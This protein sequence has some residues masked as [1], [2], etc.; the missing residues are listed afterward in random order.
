MRR[1]VF[2]RFL[3]LISCLAFAGT[4][5][6]V[7]VQGKATVVDGDTLKV[8]GHTI[9]ILNIDAPEADQFCENVACGSEATAYLR[10]LTRR[11]RVIC[12]AEARD[13]YGRLLAHCT[14]R[15]KDLGALMVQSGHAAAYRKY[16]SEYVTEERR[17]RARKLGIWASASP[18][19]P[20]EHRAAARTPRTDTPRLITGQ[21]C[22][23]KGN[24]SQRDGTRIYHL[25]GQEYY[26][27][28]RIDPRAGERWFCSEQE[29][30]AAG[31]RRSKK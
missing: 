28:T 31:W 13:R 11:T 8:A 23:I 25:P 16:S 12:Q 17:A 21:P 27:A 18:V 6:A 1:V 15:G 3:I 19:M 20:W 24:I 7:T 5:G 10:K 26:A 14:A 4:A 22:R 9:R 29:A 30:R 2:A